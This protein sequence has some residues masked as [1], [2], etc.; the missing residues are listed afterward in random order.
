MC[1]LT[2]EP[3]FSW[4]V[5][6]VLSKRKRIVAKLKSKYW[7]RTHKFGIRVPK[8]CE[9]ARKF[10]AE[11]KNTL[12]WDSILK[13]MR[14]VKIA[15]E[16]FCGTIDDI[17]PGYQKV[18]CHMIFDI[19]MGENFRRKARMVAGGHKTVTPAALTYASVVSRDSVRICLTIAALNDLK[20]LA[21]D[22]QNAYLTAKC[23]EK[24]WTIAGP[25]FGSD[26]GKIMIVTRALYG[27]KSSGAA[28]RA[29]LAEVLWDMGYR[30]SKADPDVY[31]RP[32]VKS[33]GTTYWEYILCYVDDVLAISAKP[34]STMKG[35]QA[36]FKLKDDKIEEPQVYLGASL[37][38]MT[39]QDNDECWA[40]SSDT[41]CQ[42]AVK[43]VEDV[44]AKDN[45][46]LPTKCVCPLT[47]GYRPETDVTQELKADGVQYYQELIGVLRWAVEI[48]RIDILLEVSLLSQHLA[49]PRQ[50]HLE[51][52]IHVFGYL[53]QHKK[54]R[55]MFDISQPS[56]SS[57]RFKTYDWEDFYRGAEEAIPPNMPEARGL[58]VSISLFVDADLAGDKANRRSQTGILIFINR[59][60]I[61]WY[62]KRQPSVEA[63]TFGAEFRAMKTA[64]EM[65]EALRYKLRMFGVPLDGAA[66]VFCDNEAVYKNTVLPESV[67][68][69]KHHSI[70][71]HR[72]REA[73]AANTIQVAKE[74]TTTNLADLFTKIMTSVRRTFL[75]E[76]FTY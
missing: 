24:I 71:Y 54:L 53:K 51:Q 75:L 68:R 11:N 42:A 74:G 20:I 26:A 35:V 73:V 65:V 13:E 48:G 23:R 17:P 16:E 30:P 6:H 1:S 2:D 43:N 36:K 66:S 72:C 21:C 69:K 45:L 10:D 15:F 70:A 52:V 64:V 46:R 34:E 9:Q 22:I 56:I 27:L 41:Y 18:D 31:M 8:T 38:K 39:N 44:L 60:P 32:A 50:G 37:S 62:S 61:H 12:W 28:F 4:W 3:A 7:T 67:L 29:L 63:S 14:N 57:S 40:M 47:N 5:P 25:E 33:D 76:R 49:L 59:A 55:L 58:P 19:K